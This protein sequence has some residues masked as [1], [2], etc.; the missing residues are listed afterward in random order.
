MKLFRGTFV[1][2]LVLAIACSAGVWAA[3]H[4]L[5][6]RVTEQVPQLSYSASGNYDYL[7]NLSPSYLNGQEPQPSTPALTDPL[8]PAN[9]IS[10]LQFSFQ[11]TL[12]PN[13]ALAQSP[14]EFIIVTATGNDANGKVTTVTLLPQTN[15]SGNFG[16][17][18]SLPMLPAISGGNIVLDVLVY[19]T[20]QNDGGPVFDVFDQTLTLNRSDGMLDVPR[21]LQ[22]S[23]NSF[24]GDLGYTQRGTLN[25]TVLLSASSPFG[26]ITVNPPAAASAAASAAATT[27]GPGETIIS[28]L[29]E[30][31]DGTF[32]FS[33][34]ASQPVQQ[35]N[36]TV[37]VNLLLQG[38]TS[39]SKNIVLLPATA[40]SASFR[41]P[42]TL[43]M[44]QLNT[45]MAE[46]QTE[47]GVAADTMSIQATVNVGGESQAGPVQDVFIQ[48]LSAP[49]GAAT[50][51]WSQP[52]SQ[53]KTGAITSSA[54]VANPKTYLG[55]S[56]ASIQG[57]SVVLL[58]CSVGFLGF[59]MFQGLRPRW[60]GPDALQ[61]AA[62]KTE[63]KYKDHI[64]EAS[65]GNTLAGDAQVIKMATMEDL[66][67]V[68]DE[69]GKTVIH[70]RLDTLGE[71]QLYFVI[72]ERTRYQYTLEKANTPR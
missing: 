37:A 22:Q 33:F 62:E 48:T 9:E 53:T 49:L 24:L 63:R 12:T 42:F 55:L 4:S 10:A 28:K 64:A 72:D 34:S 66:V 46:I 39:W 3:F 60:G 71:G 30:S 52:L 56:V 50:I 58:I 27:L 18:F 47:T 70:Q 32:S 36:E 40:E 68:A 13:R 31:I 19:P 69:L 29:V 15:F 54:L 8:Y 41:V 6:S 59:A 20:L 57:L 14:T 1:V 11:Y 26:A 7:V 16:T 23:Q 65:K 21:L 43:D 51:V 44:D 45:L 35:L 38:G 5:P 61:V 2:A 17:T 25:Y 67:K